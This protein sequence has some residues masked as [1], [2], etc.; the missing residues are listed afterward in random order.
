MV[1]VDVELGID[2]GEH[3]LLDGVQ[4]GGG[5]AV[6]PRGLHLHL[7]FYVDVDAEEDVLAAVRARGKSVGRTHLWTR[8]LCCPLHISLWLK[9]RLKER[10]IF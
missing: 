9:W 6:G 8:L 2:E 10:G 1:G 5:P 3:G 4:A 7:G